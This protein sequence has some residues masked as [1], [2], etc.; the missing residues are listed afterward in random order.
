M[1]AEANW[2]NRISLFKLAE[3]YKE[4]QNEE[5]HKKFMM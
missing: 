4:A 1:I 5:Y 3:E 2:R